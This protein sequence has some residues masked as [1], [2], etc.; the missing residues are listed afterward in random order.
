[1]ST[2]RQ[3]QEAVINIFNKQAVNEAF[4]LYHN[5]RGKSLTSRAKASDKMIK[6]NMERMT[7]DECGTGIPHFIA[8]NIS[9]WYPVDP[10]KINGAMLKRENKS[11]VSAILGLGQQMPKMEQMLLDFCQNYALIN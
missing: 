4:R 7:E 3:I 10:S 5:L 1:M 11:L 2:I 6:F 8:D 9:L